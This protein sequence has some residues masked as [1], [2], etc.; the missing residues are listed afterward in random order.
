MILPHTDVL[1]WRSGV[2]FFENVQRNQ[3]VNLW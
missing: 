1:R 3:T 2:H